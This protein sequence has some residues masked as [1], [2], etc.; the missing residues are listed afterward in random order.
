[1]SLIDLFKDYDVKLTHRFA[2]CSNPKRGTALYYAR[3][4]LM[5]LELSFH[6]VP[7]FLWLFYLYVTAP[8][9]DRN[10]KAIFF[11]KKI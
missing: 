9:A 3:Y 2:V 8:I 10:I 7:W 6:G 5:L 1:M 4:L 11:G